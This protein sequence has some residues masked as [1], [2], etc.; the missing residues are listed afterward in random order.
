MLELT[1]IVHDVFTGA[2]PVIGIP[3]LI[4]F[5][6]FSWWKRRHSVRVSYF[7]GE[8]VTTKDIQ[9]IGEVDSRTGRITLYDDKR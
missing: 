9:V 5:L 4:V 7:T 3:S 2:L 8:G 6:I 1:A